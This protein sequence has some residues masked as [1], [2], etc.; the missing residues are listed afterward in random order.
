[1]KEAKVDQREIK[2]VEQLVKAMNRGGYHRFSVARDNP[3]RV[4]FRLY[5]YGDLDARYALGVFA[6]DVRPYTY[7]SEQ[8]YKIEVPYEVEGLSG[9]WPHAWYEHF[10]HW[11][12]VRVFEERPISEA[13]SE[14]L[15]DFLPMYVQMIGVMNERQRAGGRGQK[16]PAYA[17]R[18]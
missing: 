6:F 15:I 17:N 14:I 16:N 2:Y 12:V 8:R 1:M 5:G 7:A 9:V 3:Y 18:G 13:V 10:E 4:E 11:P